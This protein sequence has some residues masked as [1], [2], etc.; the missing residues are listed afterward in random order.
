[1]SKIQIAK[2][3]KLMLSFLYT[4]STILTAS[5]DWSHIGCQ[6]S[7]KSMIECLLFLLETKLIL[8]HRELMIMSFQIYW[9]TILSNFSRFKWGLS[10]RLKSTSIL[11]TW[12]HLL[13]G[14]S[15]TQLPLYMILLKNSWS[16]TTK[17]HF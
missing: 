3:K 6:G 1:M 7:S 9:T 13:R 5:R 15:C 14:R 10:A 8:D 12:L 2:L 11:L 16:R 17:R 4:M